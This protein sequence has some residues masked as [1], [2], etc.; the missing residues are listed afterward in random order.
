MTTSLDWIDALELP[1]R[2][3]GFLCTKCGSRECELQTAKNTH[4]KCAKCD[5]L[6]FGQDLG[7][8]DAEMRQAMRKAVAEYIK[9]QKVEPLAFCQSDDPDNKAAFSQ[10]C[11]PK[12]TP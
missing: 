3:R 10:L 1:E 9:R 4:P 12:A 7:Y 11:T 8:S 6:G 2:R 5:Y